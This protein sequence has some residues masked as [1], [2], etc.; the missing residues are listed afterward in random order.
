MQASDVMTYRVVVDAVAVDVG[1]ARVAD[2]V[3]VHVL[4]TTVRHVHAVVLNEVTDA[5]TYIF[6]AS[7]LTAYR[8]AASIGAWQREVGNSV[9]VSVDATHHSV[10][11][12][13]HVALTLPAAAA[14]RLETHCVAITTR[15]QV[16]T[17]ALRLHATHGLVANVTSDALAAASTALW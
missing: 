16:G 3:D 1:V 10:A 17:Q 6:A 9:Q 14:R 15:L 13:P 7:V 11:S 4:L 2:A 5:Q 12:P 8:L